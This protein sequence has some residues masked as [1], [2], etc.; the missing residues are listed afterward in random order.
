MRSSCKRLGNHKWRPVVV[1][2]VRAMS[3]ESD[4]GIFFCTRPGCQ[5]VKSLPVK[6]IAKFISHRLRQ[7]AFDFERLDGIPMVGPSPNIPRVRK[8]E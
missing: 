3:P 6:P 1:E 7:L 4:Y 2:S 5:E 8:V